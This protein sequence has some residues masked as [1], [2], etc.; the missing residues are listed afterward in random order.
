MNAPEYA[1]VVPTV[2]RDS[3]HRALV[4][5]LEAPRAWAPTEIVVVD[6]RPG[7]GHELPPVV[8]H[9]RVRTLRGGGGGPAT[10]RQAGWHSCRAEWIAFLDD[11][12]HPPQDWP[13]RLCSDL[14]AADAATG[15][16]QGR[17]TV[18]RPEGRRPT[19]AERATLGLEGA[20]WITADMA[21]R[22]SALEAV[23]GFDTRFPRAYREDTDLAL[24]VL[25]AGFSLRLG[26]RECVHPLR[27]GRRWASLGA[28]RGNADDALMNAV[29]GRG[30][31]DRV[32]EAPGGLRG[33]VLTTGLAAGAALAALARRPVLAGALGAGW[34]A[35]TA[36]FAVR[37]A[38][39]G[40]A[41]PAEIIDMVVTSALIPPLACGRRI[42]GAVRHAGAGRRPGIRAILFDRDGT[43][44]EDVPYNGDPDKVRPTAGA[45][46][47]IA[48]ARR[49]G[50]AVGVVSNQSG[51]ARGLLDTG[52]VDA[53][54]R[55]V[56][57]LL[58]PFDVW[59]VCPHG[60]ADGCGCRKP[61]PGMIESA[62][63]ELGVAPAEC[64]VVGDIGSDMAAARAAGARGVLVPTNLT[65]E[66]E[67]RLSPETE[68]DLTSAVHRLV[69]GSAP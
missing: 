15:G 46:N 49:A 34:L 41:D 63:A 52:Q 50:L 17:I 30:W 44:I 48:L 10:A 21:Y 5:L 29:H 42:A 43:L 37:R 8:D 22:R 13:E 7:A 2:G 11:D 56:D 62:A 60:E 23:G 27:P 32:G 31:R 58:G 20:P 51:I 14:L 45:E 67:Q 53:V 24:R 25:D 55:R 40:P 1:V 39:A 19:D 66:D 36:G 4:P 68:P 6:D 47:A 3:L 26:E 28:Q 65:R 64:A 18:P 33:H 59:R 12:V 38:T 57:E 69:R 54:N 16:V 9:P 35:R 61:S